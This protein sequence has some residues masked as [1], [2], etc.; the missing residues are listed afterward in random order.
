MHEIGH[1]HTH[2][3]LGINNMNLIYWRNKHSHETSRCCGGKH[4]NTV[5]CNIWKRD[6]KSEWEET[7]TKIN[8]LI[9]FQPDQECENQQTQ[10]S[11][12]E[13][14]LLFSVYLINFCW[15]KKP[16][17]FHLLWHGGIGVLIVCPQRIT[18]DRVVVE[19]KS[20]V[21]AYPHLSLRWVSVNISRQRS[22][23]PQAVPQ[24][25][26]PSLCLCV[27]Q[28]DTS[29]HTQTVEGFKIQYLQHLMVLYLFSIF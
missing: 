22:I 12:D 13:M 3:L 17:L 29:K 21:S 11:L 20:A 23:S 4:V 16:N 9:K 24:L 1:T 18:P 19:K 10:Y 5:H 6:D 26:P 2:R 28:P 8:S 15:H 7:N 25:A 27:Q 14:F